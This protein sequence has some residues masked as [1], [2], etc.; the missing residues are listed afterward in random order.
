MLLLCTTLSFAVPLQ[1]NHQGRL[2]DTEGDGLSGEHELIFRIYDGADV[3]LWEETLAVDFEEGYYSVNLGEDEENNPLDEAIFASYP[4]L[5]EL[6]VDGVPLSPRHPIQSV[7]YANLSETAENVEG[8]RVNASDV[9]IDGMSVIDTDGTWTGKNILWGNIDEIPLDILDGDNDTQRQEFEVEDFISNGVIDLFPGTTLGGQNILSIS[10]NSC[11]DG[12]IVVWNAIN[13]GW[14]CQDDNNSQLSTSDVLAIV[15]NNDVLS[16]GSICD[17]NGCIGDS[18]W[19][20]GSGMIYY[21]GNHVGIGTLFPDAMLTVAG[22]VSATSLSGTLTTAAQSNITSLGVLDALAVSGDLTVDGDVLYVDSSN[23]YIGIGTTTPTQELDVQGTISATSIMGTLITSS[24]PNITEVGTIQTGTWEGDTLSDAYVSDVLTID[25]GNIENTTIGVNTPAEARFTSL[26]ANAGIEG[27]LIT[28]EQENITALGALILLVVSG[29]LTVDGDTLH[30][31]S[32]NDYVGIGTTTPNSKLEVNGMIHSTSGGITYPDGTTQTTAFQDDGY[33]EV[34]SYYDAGSG[35]NT[36]SA[37]W[38]WGD[39]INERISEG[40]LTQ[41]TLYQC[42]LLSSN[43]A[44]Y[45]GISFKIATNLASGGYK[46]Y[47]RVFDMEET[48]S[49][50]VSGCGAA[51]HSYSSGVNNA[52]G[53]GYTNT[54]TQTIT[55]RCIRLN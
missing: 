9:L 21:M 31:D 3:V 38:V 25:G 52:G 47:H 55:C 35:H 29:D 23:D 44:H 15:E 32:T 18:S 43:G 41:G 49:G 27:T 19:E 30:V 5:M 54:C 45:T 50:W 42:N 14:S 36:A 1:Y 51:I 6:S 20:E 13:L 53:F 2:L 8:G 7:P 28:A 4:L 10:P 48:N 24:Q 33:K 34:W 11:S 26:T 39:W 22:S 46:N 40:T 16:T 17:V 37:S 12:Q